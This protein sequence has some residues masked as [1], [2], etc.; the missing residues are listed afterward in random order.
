MVELR[1]AALEIPEGNALVRVTLQNVAGEQKLHIWIGMP[2]AAAIARHLEG[3]PLPR[4]MTHDL[5]ISTLTSLGARILQ[6]TIAD[7]QDDH[8]MGVLTLIFGDCTYDIDCRPSD[9]IAIAIRAD[10]PILISEELLDR[11]EELENQQIDQASDIVPGAIIID[12]DD[13]T[14]H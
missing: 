2:E 11:A 3:I 9:G 1:I 6:L 12:Q 7:V 8:Y 13:T 14:I 4:P 10:A 5:F